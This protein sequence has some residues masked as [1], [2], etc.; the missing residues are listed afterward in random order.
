MGGRGGGREWEG[1]KREK[2]WRG[3]GR[4]E[5]GGRGVKYIVGSCYPHHGFRYTHTP[6]AAFSR[7]W[8]SLTKFSR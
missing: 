8:S 7:Y 2:G 6:V 1:G 4:E 3:E 5:E